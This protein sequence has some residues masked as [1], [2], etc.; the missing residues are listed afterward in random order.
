MKK[1]ITFAL[2]ATSLLF[3]Q[4]CDDGSQL[5]QDTASTG[6]DSN[7]GNTSGTGLPPGTSPTCPAQTPSGS[8]ELAA[9]IQDTDTSL[10]GHIDPGNEVLVTVKNATA[11][12]EIC[13]QIKGGT[14][15]CYDVSGNRILDNFKSLT[16]SEA[17]D[18]QSWQWNSANSTWTLKYTRMVSSQFSDATYKFDFYSPSTGKTAKTQFSVTRAPQTMMLKADGTRVATFGPGDSVQ[19][20]IYGAQSNAAKHCASIASANPEKCRNADGTYN[21]TEF[22]AILGASGLP[23]GAQWSYDAAKRAYSISYGEADRTHFAG[24]TYNHFIYDPETN[25]FSEVFSFTI[26]N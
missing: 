11:D 8:T 2:I 12:L 24:E 20:F 21:L 4:N 1:W 9:F 15:N 6:Q 16:G 25:R 10:Y 18:G 19:Q 22:N 26:S 3:F 17:I 23:S 5:P 13:G 7:G 14:A